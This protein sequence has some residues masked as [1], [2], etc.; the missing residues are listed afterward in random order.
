MD[1]W[2]IFR[3]LDGLDAGTSSLHFFW[4]THHGSTIMVLISLRGPSFRCHVLVC[5]YLDDRSM[6][7]TKE[8]FFRLL[9]VGGGS[10]PPLLWAEDSQNKDC[11][12]HWTKWGRGV[13]SDVKR[14]WRHTLSNQKL[15]Q[16]SGAIV[17]KCFEDFH[18]HSWSSSDKIV[19]LLIDFLCTWWSY[20]ISLTRILTSKKSVKRTPLPCFHLGI[21]CWVRQTSFTPITE[22]KHLLCFVVS[23]FDTVQRRIDCRNTG[24]GRQIR[25]LL[26]KDIRK[27]LTNLPQNSPVF[28]VRNS[29]PWWWKCNGYCE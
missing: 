28:V 10:Q 13:R 4:F 21:R 2:F 3:F 18:D 14:G 20:H 19:S 7:R 12:S 24:F 25:Y 6:E 17:R 5:V 27:F 26:T 8:A 22:C 15:A 9:C 23:T 1:A 29:R 11:P 16:G